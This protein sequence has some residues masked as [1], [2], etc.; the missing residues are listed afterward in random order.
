MRGPGSFSGRGGYEFTCRFFEDCNEGIMGK[1][2]GRRG[3]T[4]KWEET[5]LERVVV[6]VLRGES[7]ICENPVRSLPWHKLLNF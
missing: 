2:T 7:G 3:S 1:E 4:V 6:C 5:L